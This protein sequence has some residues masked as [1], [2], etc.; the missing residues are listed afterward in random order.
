[1]VV[2]SFEQFYAI[3]KVTNKD[4]KEGLAC[5]HEWSEEQVKNFLENVWNT[6]QVSIKTLVMDD[7]IAK[8]ESKVDEY[9]SALEEIHNISYTA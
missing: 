1:M 9:E 7:R 5:Q 8:L 3:A 6:A 4:F 2:S